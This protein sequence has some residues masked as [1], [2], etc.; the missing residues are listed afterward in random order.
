M[1][2]RAGVRGLTGLLGLVAGL[3]LGCSVGLRH[4]PYTPQPSS[5]L[6]EVT[7]APPPGRVESV[8]AAPTRAA[9]WVDGE[10]RWRRHKWGWQPGYWAVTPHDAKFS[11]WVFIRAADG[12][13]WSAP[14]TW[15]D[16]KGAQVAAPA[17]LAVAKVDAAEIVNASGDTENVASTEAVKPREAAK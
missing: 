5:A 14:G 16:S 7:L 1:G 15:R 8:P 4:P 3:G 2:R 10:W 6:V 17:E 13:L 11:P 9:V 12:R